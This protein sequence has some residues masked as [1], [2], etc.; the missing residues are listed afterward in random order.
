[1]TK[2]LGVKYLIYNK[3]K[4]YSYEKVNTVLIVSFFMYKIIEILWFPEY[5]TLLLYLSFIFS[6]FA[7]IINKLFN[8]QF[9]RVTSKELFTYWFILSCLII[10]ILLN[11]NIEITELIW[12][13]KYI[14]I[15]IVLLRTRLWLPPIRIAYWGTMLYLFYCI[16]NGVSVYKITIGVS[17]MQL[18]YTLFL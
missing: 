3:Y 4:L 10:G 17:E 14:F 2:L 15:A 18:Y 5:S 11:N 13:F 1:M 8:R 9:N 16:V 7:F 12:Y 6:V